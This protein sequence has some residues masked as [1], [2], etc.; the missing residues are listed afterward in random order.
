MYSGTAMI[1]YYTW[2]IYVLSTAYVLWL[3]LDAEVSFRRGR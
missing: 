1:W 3:W 2:R